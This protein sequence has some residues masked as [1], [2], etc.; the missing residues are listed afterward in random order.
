MYLD[1]WIRYLETERRFSPLTVRVYADDVTALESY[2]QG[3]EAAFATF[4]E[5]RSYIMVMVERGDNPRSIN[6]HIAAL[7]SYFKYLMRTQKID[8]NPTLKLRSLPIESR[9]PEFISQKKNA[10]LMIA[11]DDDD[12]QRDALI[13]MLLYTTGMR[14][15]ELVSLTTDDIDIAQRK[16]RVTGKGS[17]QREIPLLSEICDR[18]EQYLQNNIWKGE[19]KHL[20][21]TKKS[22][23]IGVNEVYRVV[24]RVLSSAGVQGKQSP[25]T[26]RHTFATHL[27]A[28]GAPLR[29]IQELLG[30]NSLGTTQIYTHNTIEKLKESYNRA[31]PRAKE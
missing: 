3:G 19:K 11:L 27:M 4:S 24:R 2:L 28:E 22:E 1:S 21:L 18:L 6:R 12:N 9:L 20:F 13:V 16:I 7:K 26:L 17:K 15:A 5:L 31:H 29:S 25:H 10:E 23:P 8:K 14:R 30:H